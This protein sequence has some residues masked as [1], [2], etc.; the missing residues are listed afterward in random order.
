MARTTLHAMENI[1]LVMAVQPARHHR[2]LARPRCRRRARRRP[3]DRA[4]ASTP[5]ACPRRCCTRSRSRSRS[6]SWSTSTSCSARWCRRTS[7]SPA[8]SG[9]RWCWARRCWA[10]SRCCARSSW[11]STPIANGDPAA[12]AASSRSDEVSSTYTREEVAALVE[13]SRGEGLLEDEEY[14][15]LAGALGFTEKT[16]AAV[17]MPPDELDDRTPRLD[18]RRRRGA[19][20]GDRLQPV[21]GALGDD[22]ELLGYLHIKDVLETDE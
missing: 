16:V 17:L 15:R 11:S 8:P 18:R 2:L 9:P 22:G 14:D 13:E 1:S 20:R 19:V 4:G 7:R 3:P 6:P 10:S 12:A 21:P 5:S